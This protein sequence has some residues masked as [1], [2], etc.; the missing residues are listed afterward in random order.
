[1]FLCRKLAQASYPE[2]GDK[3]GGKD[4]STVINACQKIEKLRQ[5]DL[6]LNAT[7]QALEARLT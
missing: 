6:E 7:L 3:F 4:H 2:I 5:Q 1:M